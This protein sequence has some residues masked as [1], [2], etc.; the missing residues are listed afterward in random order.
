[1][2]WIISLSNELDTTEAYR[3]M[4]EKFGPRP[5]FYIKGFRDQKIYHGPKA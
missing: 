1:M 5:L 2:S 4:I 3:Y